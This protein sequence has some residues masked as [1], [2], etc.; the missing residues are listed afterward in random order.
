MLKKDSDGEIGCEQD[1]LIC[2]NT[3]QALS[4]LMDLKVHI[5][6]AMTFRGPSF[7]MWHHEAANALHMA[8]RKQYGDFRSL[9]TLKSAE[10]RVEDLKD[11]GRERVTA[12]LRA[13]EGHFKAELLSPSRNFITAERQ[14]KRAEQVWLQEAQEQYRLLDRNIVRNINLTHALES[15]QEELNREQAKIADIAKEIGKQKLYSREPDEELFR[16][17]YRNQEACQQHEVRI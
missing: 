17:L 2:E 9:Q 5:Q 14:A 10:V 3:L 11:L 7:H 16:R 4:G 12:Y 6:P 15:L 13:L 8:L 1:W